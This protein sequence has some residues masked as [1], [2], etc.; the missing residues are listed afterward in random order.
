VSIG[1]KPKRLLLLFSSLCI[2]LAA[3]GLFPESTFLLSDDSRLP[4]WFTLDKGISRSQISVEMSNYISPF[5]STATFVLKW[6][7]GRLISKEKGKVHGDHPIY[8]GPPTS[9]PLRQY[10]SYEIVTVSGVSE[11]IEHR[12]MEPVF[13]VSDDAA[14][15]KQLG[16]ASTSNRPER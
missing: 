13:F 5:G 9:D 6:R 16:L 1:L 3:C 14:V 2:E 4:K 7:D 12:A 15:L 8:L 10:P 11:V